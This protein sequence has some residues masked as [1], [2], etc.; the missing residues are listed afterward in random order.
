M[1]N[2]EITNKC[3]AVPSSMY[4]ARDTCT[5]TAAAM[6]R[7]RFDDRCLPVSNL[8]AVRQRGFNTRTWLFG[9]HACK[10]VRISGL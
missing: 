4:S 7:T 1:H 2:K 5:L 6:H 8:D 10:D 3:L 9:G